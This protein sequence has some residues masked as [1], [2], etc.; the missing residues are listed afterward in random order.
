MNDIKIA[1]AGAG[2]VGLSLAVLLSQYNDVTCITTT[3]K[4]A[5][6]INSGFSP[7]QDKEIEAFLQAKRE[8]KISLRLNAGTEGARAYAEAELIIIAVPTNYDERLNAFDTSVVESVIEA[9][10]ASGSAAPIVIKSTVP[11][12]FTELVSERYRRDNIIFSPEFLRESKALYD[13][14]HPSRIVVGVAD[15]Q[16]QTAREFA[17]LL[18]QAAYKPLITAAGEPPEEISVLCCRPSEAEAIKLFSNAYLAVRVSFFNE[19]DTYAEAKGL[20]TGRIIR[21][22]CMDPRIGAHYNNPS[23]GYGGYCLPKDTEQL[24]SN[25]SGIPQNLIEAVVKSNATRKDFVA[26]SAL[27]KGADTVGVYR[28]TMKSNSDNFRSAAVQGVIERL[29]AAGAEVLIYEPT[30][31]DRDTALG[32]PVVND[33]EQFK[34]R[35]GLIIANRY[36][37]CL[38]DVREKVYT[39]DLFNRD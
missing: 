25:Y 6:M 36:D 5:E 8:G 33:I 39:R 16:E 29:K 24:L 30:L 20:D 10:I 27:A 32:C 15:G 26:A 12:G 22:V 19:L 13:N 23:F 35:S 1:I 4:K 11:I 21:G 34:A 7:I 14:L 2:Y 31:T 17:G 37:T 38:D 3:P 28:L 9:V 18:T